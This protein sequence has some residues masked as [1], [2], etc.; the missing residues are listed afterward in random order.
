MRT[1]DKYIDMEY[2]TRGLR[3]RRRQ[4]EE[5]NALNLVITNANKKIIELNDQ[6]YELE[7]EVLIQE[8]DVGPIKY[9]A[10]LI[11]DDQQKTCWTKQ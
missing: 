1:L 6:K 10:E 9:I 7:R 3:E 2:V 11:Y 4:E 5:R 8:A